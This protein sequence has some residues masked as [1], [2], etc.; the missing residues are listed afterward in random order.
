MLF[1]TGINFS[2]ELGRYTFCIK[3]IWEKKY[4]KLYLRC[5]IV[6]GLPYANIKSLELQEKMSYLNS[7]RDND[8]KRAGQQYYENICW[9][10]INQ[11][12]G[13]AIRH[14]NDY[15]SILLIDSRYCTQSLANLKEKLPQ[16]I[17]DSF[18]Q[19]QS[20]TFDNKKITDTLIK[21]N[22]QIKLISNIFKFRIC[23]ILVLRKQIEEINAN[24][25]IMP[26]F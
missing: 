22:P 5:V 14:Q 9:K 11:S 13:R 2:D 6:V 26:I 4:F 20:S 12:I 24:S 15:S 18:R 17:G 10:A 25:F 1:S 23:V 19:E 3:L 16:W 8:G 21:V 7:L